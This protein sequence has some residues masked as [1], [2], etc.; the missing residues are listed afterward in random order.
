VAAILVTIMQPAYL[1]W[2]GYFDRIL[3]SELFVVLDHVR[4]D[5]NSR[6]KFANRNRVRTKEGWSWLTVPLQTKG[7]AL[8]LNKLSINNAQPW[9]SKHWQTIQHC[10]GKARH[11]SDYAAELKSFY[12][13]PVEN[14][15]QL[16]KPMTEYFLRAL[17]IGVPVYYSSQLP[18]AGEK[19]DLIVNICKHFGATGYLSG[20][21]GRDYLN[22]EQF[23]RMG[24]DLQFHDYQHPQYPQ[25]WPGFEPFMAIID[26]LFNCGGDA[27][28]IFRSPQS[29]SRKAALQS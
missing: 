13:R 28:E 17:S 10:Y 29:I 2:L 14:L 25:C 19:Q 3:A 18:I 7:H 23:E 27:R 26:L 12:E 6:T 21:F 9:Q 20:P 11:F 5:L 8:E 22:A 4:V 15:V 1:P 16:T 24:I